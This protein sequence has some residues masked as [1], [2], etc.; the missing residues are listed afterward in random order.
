[1]KFSVLILSLFLFSCSQT[2][3]RNESSRGVASLEDLEGI[4]PAVYYGDKILN[5]ARR[6]E[7]GRM[8]TRGMS[9]NMARC[10]GKTGTEGIVRCINLGGD[11]NYRTSS[12]STPLMMAVKRGDYSMVR[13]LIKYGASINQKDHMGNTPLLLGV[14]DGF[15]EVVGLLLANGA[16]QSIRNNLGQNAVDMASIYLKEDILEILNQ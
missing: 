14:K 12:G 6:G 3:D 8:R 15:T 11:V 16:D 10:G 9:L 1:M 13:M 5:I 2:E 4:N 7:E